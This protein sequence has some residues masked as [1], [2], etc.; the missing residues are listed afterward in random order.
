MKISQIIQLSDHR[1][2]PLPQGNWLFY[3]EWN[4]VLFV[5]YKVPIDEL[6]KWVPSELEID[7]FENDAYVSVVLFRMEN[8]RP[9]LLPKFAPLSNFDE[10]NIRT[11]VK[12]K[13]ESGVYFLS[14]EAGNRLSSFLAKSLSGL[15]YRFSKMALKK[16][17]YISKNKRFG[18]CVKAA[19]TVGERIHD[20]TEKDIWL[21]ERYA[22]FQNSSAQINTYQVHHIP[23]PIN[24]VD[25]SR[26]QIHYPR[27]EVLFQ[28]DI[29]AIHY[30][31]GVQVLAW[32]G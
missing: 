16:G 23:W 15:P 19:F 22:V 32:K 26:F 12:Y 30:S 4:Q 8:V 29:N 21:T 6:R 28:Q 31:S 20:K 5:H 27:F 25:V 7:T 3:Q 9:R 1:P 10:I 24:R 11:Y 17:N 14:I 13:G 18:D 2:T